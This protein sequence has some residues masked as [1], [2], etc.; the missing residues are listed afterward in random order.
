MTPKEFWNSTYRDIKAFV[1]GN[2]KMQQEDKKNTIVMYEA[3]ANKIIGA[4][5]WSR[6]KNKSLIKDIFRDLFKEEL[7]NNK[8]QSIEEQVRILRSMK[9]K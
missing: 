7:D 2:M 4:L 5:S 9:G 3:M 8:P 1:D 6:P